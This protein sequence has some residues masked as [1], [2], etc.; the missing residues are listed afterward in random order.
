MPPWQRLVRYYGKDAHDYRGAGQKLGQPVDP[1][2]DVGQAVAEKKPVKVQS[3]WA[4]NLGDLEGIEVEK[5]EAPDQ[6]AY[7]E[8]LFME[9]LDCGEEV[10]MPQV[11]HCVGV[12]F[13][14]FADEAG[15]EVP[16][17]PQAVS[18][19]DKA[20]GYHPD[21]IIV[22]KAFQKDIDCEA[23]LAVIIAKSCKNVSPDDALK[24]VV[25]ITCATNAVS[26]KDPLQ[27]FKGSCQLGPVIVNRLSIKDWNE[28][29]IQGK[30]NG[31]I[32][33]K[34]KLGEMAFSIPEIISSLSQR[35]RLKPGTIILTGTP[36]GAGW[37]QKPKRALKDGDVF[38]TTISHGV[39]S[40]ISQVRFQK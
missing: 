26:R 39:G 10:M 2:I 27:S 11:V 33:Q 15:V 3:W 31:K 18:K 12:N 32:V 8:P 7:L 35:T 20:V 37:Y 38:T 29:E 1:N 13:R 21:R 40:V 14:S 17:Q 34:A 22:P 30:L 25:G 36:A 24:Y 6:I 19:P 5:D 23:H 16:E 9:D 4:W 28:V